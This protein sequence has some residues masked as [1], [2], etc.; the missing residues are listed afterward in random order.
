MDSKQEYDQV[1]PPPEQEQLR[2]IVDIVHTLTKEGGSREAVW[3]DKGWSV[4]D[5]NVDAVS[6]SRLTEEGEKQHPDYPLVMVSVFKKRTEGR[7]QQKY[8]VTK[9]NGNLRIDRYD[10]VR[11]P[12]EEKEK[13]EWKQKL[14]TMTSQEADEALRKL[15]EGLERRKEE[16]AFQRRVGY[17]YVDR[18]ET[19]RLIDRLSK[20]PNKT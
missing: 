18:E 13:E 14:D 20:L 11:T 5:G 9:D 8:D 16:H 17:S 12:E 4:N 2:N 19:Q 6:V 10:S 1:G 3:I 15:I 7:V